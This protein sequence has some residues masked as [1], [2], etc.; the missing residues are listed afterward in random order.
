[1]KTGRVAKRV[2]DKAAEVNKKP[3]AEVA[4]RP[5]SGELCV[6]V[7]KRPASAIDAK[8][9]KAIG[10]KPAKAGKADAAHE[11]PS[12]V[13]DPSYKSNKHAWLSKHYKAA[14]KV[15]QMAEKPEEKCCEIAREARAN[16]TTAWDA[17][18]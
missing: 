4:K 2:R 3:A 15:S 10:G 11:Y 16:A 9:A 6:D 1:M 7:A 18:N 5:A 17:N 12:V 13:W 8:P 14:L